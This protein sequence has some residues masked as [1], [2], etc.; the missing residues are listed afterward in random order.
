M[1]IRACLAD[2][3][4]YNKFLI[5]VGLTLVGAV[6]FTA[7][8]ATLSQ[9]VFGVDMTGD[10]SLIDQYADPQVANAFRM[11]QGLAAIGTFI[12]PAW[13]AAYL[14][15]R[16]E[17]S[18]LGLNSI[19][20][21][22]SFVM[23][24]LLLIAAVPFIN[25]MMQVN[26]ELH[27]PASLKSLEDWMI[28]SEEQAGKITKLLLGSTAVSDLLINLLVIAIIPAIGEELL[29]RGVIQKQFI[30]LT[31]SK[32]AA[33]VLTSLLFSA[34]HM[35]FFGFLPRFALGV[36]LG[37]LYVW[38]GS[39][40]LPIM[41]HFFNNATAVIL[42]WLAARQGIPFNPDTLGTEPGQDLLLGGSVLLTWIGVWM[43]QRKLAKTKPEG[44]NY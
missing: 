1:Q 18:Y 26:S 41:A 10:P 25:W 38:S 9:L 6:L 13:V 42:V 7:I 37:F 2:R 19:P 22:S 3:P 36:L 43:L 35:Q 28:A 4:P 32:G 39:L 16:D 33:V 29:F 15:S 14:F 21:N 34:L 23:V 40:W 31:E 17:K 11:F 44:F 20:E 5:I 27:L 24:F 8:G 30:A 12:L